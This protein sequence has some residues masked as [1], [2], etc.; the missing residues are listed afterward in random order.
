MPMAAVGFFAALGPLPLGEPG[1]GL[2][3]STVTVNRRMFTN[4][5]FWNYFAVAVF[6]GISRFLAVFGGFYRVQMRRNST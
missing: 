6:R 1:D 3:H 2:R 5:A 4:C